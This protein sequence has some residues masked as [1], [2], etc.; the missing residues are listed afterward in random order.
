MAAIIM[1]AIVRRTPLSHELHRS[2]SSLSRRAALLGGSATA[3]AAGIGLLAQP[4]R[5]HE[6]DYSDHPLTGIWLAMANPPIPEDPQFPATS[7]FA[8]DGTVLLVFPGSQVGPQ[9]PF[10]GTPVLGVWEPDS[11]RRGHFTAVQVMSTTDGILLGTLTIDGF[12]EVS[13]DGETLIDDGSRATIT[14]RD[15]TGAIVNQIIPN[16]QPAGRP[17]TAVRLRVGNPGFPDAASAATPT[18]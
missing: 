7:L 11:D 6:H 4:A 13:E 2:A 9:G 5:A 17:V 10:L 1:I 15:A 3:T 12:P 16:G 18:S 8:A 14:M